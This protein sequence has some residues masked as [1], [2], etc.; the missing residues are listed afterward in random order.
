VTR[1]S[2]PLRSNNVKAL[3][4]A[5]AVWVFATSLRA[6]DRIVAI[7]SLP[8]LGVASVQNKVFPGSVVQDRA[9]LL[10]SVGSDLWRAASDPLGDFWMVTDRGPNAQLKVHGE[11]RRTLLLPEYAPMIVRT[12]AR[13]GGKARE[14]TVVEM[15]PLTSAS[16]RSIGGLPNNL[17]HDEIAFDAAG[18]KPLGVNPS[19]VDTEGLVRTSQGDFWLTEEYRPSLLHVDRQGRVIKRYIPI[20]QNLTKADYDV[21][22]TLPAVYV[23]RQK[24]RGFEALAISGDQRV[25]YLGMQSPLARP[26]KDT[27]KSSRNT[28]ILAFDIARDQATAEYVYR[29]DRADEFDSGAVQDDVNLCAL[30]A[31][32]PKTLLVLERTDARAKIYRV[33]LTTATDIL[34]TP[35]HDRQDG[36]TLEALA[37]PAKHGIH[38]L[39]K[40]LIVDLGRFEGIPSKIE[41][42]AV[43]NRFT[44]AVANDNDFDVGTIDQAGNNVGQ[45]VPSQIVVVRLA[46]ALF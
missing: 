25:L 22:D 33:D 5:L 23:S 15:L 39:A 19:G 42:L 46:K 29:F 20:G 41:G 18:E 14:L 31:L 28:R 27:A 13:A 26:N 32:G 2:R 1:A 37:D 7:C 12:R 4:A 44:I 9:I 36:E 24:N 8:R 6:D 38:V 17:V 3:F 30:T 35:W 11:K 21:A 43:H 40:T 10:G 16:G 34:P 45:G